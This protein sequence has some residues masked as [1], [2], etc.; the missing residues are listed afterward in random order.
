MS[1]QHCATHFHGSG[2]LQWPINLPTWVI[3]LYLH[4]G[5]LFTNWCS[6]QCR[7]P[8]DHSVKLAETSL[9]KHVGWDLNPHN[10]QDLTSECYHLNHGWH[11]S[12]GPSLHLTALVL[13]KRVL[14]PSNSPGAHQMGLGS[15]RYRQIKRLCT[16]T[17]FF[18]INTNC[19]LKQKAQRIFQG[20][21]LTISLMTFSKQ[22]EATLNIRF[23]LKSGAAHPS[24]CFMYFAGL[25]QHGSLVCKLILPFTKMSPTY[26]PPHP[27]QYTPVCTSF[28]AFK[29]V[30]RKQRD[31]D[32]LLLL[33]FSSV[34]RLR[35]L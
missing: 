19:I 34:P 9:L 23:L 21:S 33:L 17:I 27:S 1:S 20:S 2:N 10:L 25:V 8:K 18:F 12:N 14:A 31:Q 22:T 3:K 28:K 26:I 32:L 16:L 35:G 29:M 6:Q 15:I 24:E 13:I 30:I 7:T 4:F 11:S 5:T